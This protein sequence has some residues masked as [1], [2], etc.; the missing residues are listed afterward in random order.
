[1]GGQAMRIDAG[2][3]LKTPGTEHEF[4][5]SR[6]WRTIDF[7]GESIEAA[8]PVTV[9]G[10]Y[11]ARSGNV[12]VRGS[13][14]AVVRLA[15]GRC[16][17]AYDQRISV[18][19]DEEYYPGP[20]NGDRDGYPFEGSLIDLKEMVENNIVMHLPAKRLCREDCPGLC[21]DCGQDFSQ[22]PCGCRRDK[23]ENDGFCSGLEKLKAL[24]EDDEEV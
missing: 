3:A 2:A 4:S 23:Q 19:F 18:T 24:L 8:G 14:G 7:A 17:R 22:G 15:C 6:P 1:M 20:E 12:F 11:T 13:L 21:P 16:L 5:F 10:T 9:K